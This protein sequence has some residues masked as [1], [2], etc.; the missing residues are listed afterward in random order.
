MIVTT[1]GTTGTYQISNSSLRPATPLRDRPAWL[2]HLCNRGSIRPGWSR[3][4]GL[5]SK[6]MGTTQVNGEDILLLR[7]KLPS[8]SVFIFHRYPSSLKE[9][10]VQTH[11]RCIQTTV[12]ERLRVRKWL[13]NRV[14]HKRRMSE[15]FRYS[16]RPHLAPLFSGRFSHICIHQFLSCTSHLR[17]NPEPP[18]G[19]SGKS[20]SNFGIIW[21]LYQPLA[22]VLAQITN[23]DSKPP[24]YD[25][26]RSPSAVAKFYRG[27]TVW[28]VVEMQC[29]SF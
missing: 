13:T 16:H 17:N 20:I 29:S 7:I 9:T 23:G 11:E 10:D 3:A 19:A 18:R 27:T 8:W 12:H 14:A 1:S 6:N 5:L 4:Y 28:V 2:H 15:C 24:R 22:T 26:R 25:G 21:T